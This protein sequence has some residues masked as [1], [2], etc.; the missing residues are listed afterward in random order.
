MS[1]TYAIA[2]R[3]EAEAYSHDPVLSERYLEII[4]AIAD[5]LER[6]VGLEDLMGSAIDAQ[7]LASS[8]TLF[9][10]VAERPVRGGGRGVT[11]RRRTNRGDLLTP[12]PLRAFRCAISLD[13]NSSRLENNTNSQF[14]NTN[15]QTPTALGLGSWKLGVGT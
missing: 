2:D 7:K 15:S 12:P 9:G 13:A 3:A 14:P 4:A 5:Q 6:G 11:R 10:D 8:L 1:R